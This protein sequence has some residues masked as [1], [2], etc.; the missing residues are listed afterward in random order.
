MALFHYGADAREAIQF[1]SEGRFRQMN[2]MTA[3]R[4]ASKGHIKTGVKPMK[5]QSEASLLKGLPR[6]LGIQ[7][8]VAL[9]QMEHASS[10]ARSLG[11]GGYNFIPIPVRIVT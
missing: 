11:L 6:D 9:G 5:F 4:P 8:K 10:I 2:G 1:I 3:S 7:S